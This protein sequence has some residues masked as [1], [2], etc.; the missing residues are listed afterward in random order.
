METLVYGGPYH[1]EVSD[2]ETVQ[3]NDVLIGEVWLCS[4]QSNMDMRVG[5]RYSVF[6]V[7][8]RSPY[9]NLL[10]FPVTVSPNGN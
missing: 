6:F 1:I 2:G 5:G 9:S 3:I 4:G 10:L 8:P 7:I